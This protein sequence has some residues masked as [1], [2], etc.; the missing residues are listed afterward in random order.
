MILLEVVLTKFLG[1]KWH[2]LIPL[3]W[4]LTIGFQVLCQEN[5][6]ILRDQDLH[7]APSGR[8]YLSHQHL[9]LFYLTVC[10]S[11]APPETI[12]SWDKDLEWRVY[13][14][15]ARKS[16]RRVGRWG[17][18]RRQPRAGVLTSP[19]LHCA[20][21]AESWGS[22]GKWCNPCPRIIPSEGQG[23]WGFYVSTPESHRW[24]AAWHL[25]GSGKSPQSQML[26]LAFRKQLTSPK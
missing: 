26:A 9:K 3:R 1:A 15:G 12:Q 4:I 13:L 24:K 7:R 11:L 23:S 8:A 6:V 2:Y 5:K 25:Q 16:W 14:T 21:R 22:S 20:T 18:K 17:G 10:Q 19:I